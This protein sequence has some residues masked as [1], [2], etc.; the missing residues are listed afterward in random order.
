MI[1]LLL[2]AIA[3]TAPAPPISFAGDVKG[4]CVLPCISFDGD[5]KPLP[6][7]YITWPLQNPVAGKAFPS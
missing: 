6:D 5:V 1:A 7:R 2:T 3:L 4:T